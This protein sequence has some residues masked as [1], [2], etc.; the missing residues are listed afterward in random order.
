MFACN[1][2][3]RPG[4]SAA[5]LASAVSQAST[6]W[7]QALASTVLGMFLLY[8]ALWAFL[9]ARAQAQLRRKSY[10]KCA[11]PGLLRATVHAAN[12]AVLCPELLAVSACRQNDT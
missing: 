7:L 5:S 9:I 6:C 8:V 10:Q 2:L 4:C 12:A 1:C 11:L 3:P